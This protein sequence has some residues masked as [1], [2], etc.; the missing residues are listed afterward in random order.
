MSDP[1]NVCE[2]TVLQLRQELERLRFDKK[3]TPRDR[4]TISTALTSAT[5]LH[6]RL[7]GALEISKSMIVRSPHWAEIVDTLTAALSPFPDATAAAAGALQQLEG[8]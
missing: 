7:C 6:A 4:A 8:L 1:K 5:R 3:A 2:A